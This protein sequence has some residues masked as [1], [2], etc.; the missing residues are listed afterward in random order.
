MAFER[1]ALLLEAV[2]KL[3]TFVALHSF[4]LADL[5][6]TGFCKAEQRRGGLPAGIESGAY[7]RPFTL[8][9]EID[10]LV[11]HTCDAYGETPWC[12]VK[13]NLTGRAFEKP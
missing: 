13:L 2:S 3:F 5:D 9:H 10:L 4:E 6:A 12:C 11:T 8:T 7:R 1:L